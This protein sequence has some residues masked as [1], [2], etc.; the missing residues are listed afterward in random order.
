MAIN[1]LSSPQLALYKAATPGRSLHPPRCMHTPREGK[2]AG[3]GLQYLNSRRCFSGTFAVSTLISSLT[4]PSSVKLLLQGP[5][6]IVYM[7]CIFAFLA[8]ETGID[9]FTMG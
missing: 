8:Q 1:Q 3:L 7:S 9:F 2:E 4:L 6:Q 5:L